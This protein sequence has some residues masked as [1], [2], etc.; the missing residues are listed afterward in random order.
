MTKVS[1]MSRVL[2]LKLSL[3]CH[4]GESTLAWMCVWI[5]NCI[6]QHIFLIVTFTIVRFKKK[7]KE[8]GQRELEQAKE[9]EKAYYKLAETTKR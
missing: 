9:I 4:G 1:G 5:I 3:S 8:A 2:H 6:Y 7:E